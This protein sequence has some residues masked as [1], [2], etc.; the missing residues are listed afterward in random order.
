M[1]IVNIY[2]LTDESFANSKSILARLMKISN[3][4]RWQNGHYACHF[5][6]FRLIKIQ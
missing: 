4:N 3:V 6:F 5:T 2:G 1:K